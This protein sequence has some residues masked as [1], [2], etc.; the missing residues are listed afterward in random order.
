MI[1]LPFFEVT[2]AEQLVR[3]ENALKTWSKDPY[4][5]GNG[6]ELQKQLNDLVELRES[7]QLTV[8]KLVPFL[9]EVLAAKLKPVE[10][11]QVELTDAQSKDLKQTGVQLDVLVPLAQ[12][13]LSKNRI[14]S[15]FQ[16]SFVLEKY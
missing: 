13:I 6:S 11:T 9:K 12:R 3:Q 15:L 4:W 7:S 2:I 10:D 1:L 5:N 14:C 16:S 8:E